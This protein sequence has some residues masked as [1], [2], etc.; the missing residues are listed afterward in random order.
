MENLVWFGLVVVV[1]V[2]LAQGLKHFHVWGHHGN[3]WLKTFGLPSPSRSHRYSA[4]LA[5][6]QM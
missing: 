2:V 5:K 6:W 1:V 4:Q 3:V